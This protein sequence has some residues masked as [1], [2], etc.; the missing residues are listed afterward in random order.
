VTKDQLVYWIKESKKLLGV[1]KDICEEKIGLLRKVE[2]VD[3]RL[4]LR[5]KIERKREEYWAL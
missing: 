1:T 5:K 3:S 2:G 4:W